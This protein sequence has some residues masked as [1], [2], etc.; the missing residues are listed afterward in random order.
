MTP[1]WPAILA[2]DSDSLA[3]RT[4]SL[5][6]HC[7]SVVQYATEHPSRKASAHWV[8]DLALQTEEVVTKLMDRQMSL[9]EA[10]AGQVSE[11]SSSSVTARA[12]KALGQISLSPLPSTL[13]TCHPLA[14]QGSTEEN[15]I[16]IRWRDQRAS[17]Y[18][19]WRPGPAV[20]AVQAALTACGDPAVASVRVAGA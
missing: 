15:K 1:Q 4:F 11:T 20:E 2:A 9:L 6:A 18:K 19:S 7:R 3:Q 14:L 12:Q 13:P 17:P 5:V 16:R 10:H 8:R